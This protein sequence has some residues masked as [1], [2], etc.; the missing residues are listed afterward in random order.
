MDEKE[1]NLKEYL[2]DADR[3]PVENYEEMLVKMGTMMSEYFMRENVR[4]IRILEANLGHGAQAQLFEHAAA[5][6]IS[7]MESMDLPDEQKMLLILLQVD[8]KLITLMAGMA[9]TMGIGI[10]AAEEWR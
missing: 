8:V 6:C 4:G 10:A 2:S 7:L 9:L 3:M 1:F 5:C